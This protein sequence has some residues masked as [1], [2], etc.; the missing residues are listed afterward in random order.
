[1]AAN[2]TSKS[3]AKASGSH[4]EAMF[5][6][7]QKTQAAL[8]EDYKNAPMTTPSKAGSKV[9]Q[10]RHGKASGLK[11]SYGSAAPKP[12][13][14]SNAISSKFEKKEYFDEE[15]VLSE[16]IQVLAQWIRESRY[17]I[18]FTGAG[19]STSTGIPDFRS[20]VA[21]GCGSAR[22]MASSYP[23]SKKKCKVC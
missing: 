22:L 8:Q 3:N 19:I 23:P 16:K 17:C 14:R 10:A 1:M 20:G 12:K 18:V 7:A 5:A 21:L 11:P 15:D 13:P 4:M 2:F 6:Q 9:P